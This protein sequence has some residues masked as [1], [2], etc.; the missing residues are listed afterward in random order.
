MSKSEGSEDNKAE[1][2]KMKQLLRSAIAEDVAKYDQN[3]AA[4]KDILA[5]FMN[6]GDIAYHEFGE[7]LMIPAVGAVIQQMSGETASLLGEE[8]VVFDLSVL[9]SCAIAELVRRDHPSD[10]I[11]VNE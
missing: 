11:G 9:L 4:F 5:G 7:D 8:K 6:I 3:L 1:F 10:L 2:A